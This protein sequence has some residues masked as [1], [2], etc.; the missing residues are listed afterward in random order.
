MYKLKTS[1]IVSIAFAI[2]ASMSAPVYTRDEGAS[3]IKTPKGDVALE[4]VGQV[5][6]PSPTTSNQYGYLSFLNGVDGIFNPGPPNETTARFTF[7]TEARTTRVINNGAL[8]IVNRTGTTTIYMHDTPGNFAT[9]IRFKMAHPCLPRPSGSRSSLTQLRGHSPPRTSTRLLQPRLL[10]SA[11][12]NSG[13]AGSGTS[14]E[15]RSTVGRIPRR[16]RRAL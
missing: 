4:L 5:M 7:F 12:M 10:L 15:R 13:S 2:L 16:H 9:P 1:L 14:S 8:R 11:M 3:R 6:N